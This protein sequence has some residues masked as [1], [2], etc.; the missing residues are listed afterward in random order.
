MRVEDMNYTR[1][2]ILYSGGA[3]STYFIE[4]EETAK[5]LLHYSGLN[6]DRTKIA[7]INANLYNKFITIKPV[8]S[9]MPP[10][11]ETNQIHALYDAQMILDACVTALSFGL[12]GIVVGFNR[13]DI[14]VDDKPILQLVHKIDPNFKILMPLRDVSS[15]EIRKYIKDKNIKTSSCLF[16]DNCGFCAKCKK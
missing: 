7:T 9:P 1:F 14:G 16:S 15:K 13:D 10:D 6:S 5:F 12:E 11:G 8:V 2:L 3:D 4:R